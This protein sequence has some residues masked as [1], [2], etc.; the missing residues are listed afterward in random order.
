[1]RD[2]RLRRSGAANNARTEAGAVGDGLPG[3]VR[4][5]IVGS[6]IGAT[7][8]ASL[9]AW[10]GGFFGSATGDIFPSGPD[11]FC[12]LRDGP[13]VVAVRQEAGF[14]QVYDPDRENQQ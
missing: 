4:K 11:A 5:Y 7:F 14:R 6:I 12:A 13:G 3:W 8:A 10:L 9:T 2:R 1:M